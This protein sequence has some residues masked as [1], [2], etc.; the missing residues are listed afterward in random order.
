MWSANQQMQQLPKA[1]TM[2]DNTAAL[3]SFSEAE[4][5]GRVSDGSM[6][7]Q[8]CSAGRR[9]CGAMLHA[10]FDVGFHITM[11]IH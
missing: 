9:Q 3:A 5:F 8:R 2:D 11:T 1:M 6:P 4:V 7:H 10:C